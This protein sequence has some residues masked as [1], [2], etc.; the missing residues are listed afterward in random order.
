MRRAL[1]AS[2][3]LAL[4]LT[5]CPGSNTP[6]P[7]ASPSSAGSPE[8]RSGDAHCRSALRAGWRSLPEAPTSR[9]E[10][11]A[12]YVDGSIYVAGGLTGSGATAIVERYQPA[13]RTWTREPDLP[14]A[15]H[16]AT[17]V[18]YE[19][20]LVVIGGFLS[21]GEAS[22]SVFALGETGWRALPPLRRPRA[23]GAAGVIDDVIVVAG[24]Q[25]GGTLVAE[26]ELYDGTTWSDAARI[27]TPRDHLAGAVFRGR[28]YAIGGRELD[29]EAVLG[30]TERYDP[31]R[32]SWERLDPMPTPR[33]GLG[34]AALE[35]VII[36]LGG[37]GPTEAAGPD[38]VYEHM[39]AFA[40]HLERWAPLGSTMRTARHGIGVVVSRRFLYAVAGGPTRGGSESATVEQFRMS[41]CK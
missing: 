14:V 18:T 13:T 10:V 36:A 34:A 15:L 19:G 38:G 7:A 5:A 24:G 8:Q 1:L 16:H 40:P 28:F 17:G 30:A 22:S 33:G 3:V 2:T 23:A 12:A 39:E 37:E 27:P 41:R 26:T 31:G 20:E 21:S 35:G 6:E 4:A 29:I 11:A 9:L 32:D 25:A